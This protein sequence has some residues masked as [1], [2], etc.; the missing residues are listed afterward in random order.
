MGSS[1]L[2]SRHAHGRN[3]CTQLRMKTINKVWSSLWSLQMAG[4]CIEFKL[5]HWTLAH[6][7]IEFRFI[8]NFVDW[9]ERNWMRLLRWQMLSLY[10]QRDLLEGHGVCRAVL[11]LQKILWFIISCF[12]KRKIN[13]KNRKMLK[14][15]LKLWMMKL[16]SWMNLKRNKNKN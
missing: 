11:K 15:Q 4:K 14:L 13:H 2:W 8:R 3:I 16:K 1:C 9:E 10:M 6:L 5:Y 7:R 12:R